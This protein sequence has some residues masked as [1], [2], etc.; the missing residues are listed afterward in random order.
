MRVAQ[1]VKTPQRRGAETFAF[2]L[3]EAL[4]RR[5]HAT[6]IL[7]LY[8]YDGPAPLPVR[9]QDA[10]LG[11]DRRLLERG[12]GCQ[13]LLLRR[14][15]R[16]LA[17]F[18]PD[19]VQVNGS[20]S[21]KYG[22]LARRLARGRWP[23]IARVIGSPPDW[24]GPRPRRWLYSRLVLSALDGA[25]AVSRDTLDGLHRAYG[26]EVPAVVVPRGIDPETVRPERP[27]SEVRRSLGA[28]PDDPVLLYVGSLAPEKR[29]DRLLRV[30]RE[31]RRR[32]PGA[33][34]WIAG[35]GPLEDELNASIQALGLAES[36]ALLGV[37]SALG[38]LL[39]AAD[40]LV[41]TSD[42]EGTPG[43]VLEAAFAGL[44]AVATRVGGVPECVLDGQTGLLADP[45]DE[46]A[47][48]TAV[49]DLLSDPACR[50]SM[51]ETARRRAEE[52]FSLDLVADEILAF[53]RERIRHAV[54]TEGR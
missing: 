24:A 1:I 13:H 17:V 39:A 51:G 22:S 27:R 46:D 42:T 44:P 20:R 54:A 28:G 23:L 14:L 36:V 15:V 52:R 45:G 31:V 47:L 25:V 30:F 8:G 53:Y 41:L 10:V 48:A 43:V 32:R 2:Q 29:L 38:D 6:S 16:R 26:L 3:S 37:V 5:G 7:Y 49:L 4:E 19:V 18:R 11:E 21:V 12:L 9:Q 33:R 50:R 34:L 40:L 35:G